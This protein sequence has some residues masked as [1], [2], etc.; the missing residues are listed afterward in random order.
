MAAVRIF[1]FRLGMSTIRAN[2]QLRIATVLLSRRCAPHFG[3]A[4][5]LRNPGSLI[6]S[7]VILHANGARRID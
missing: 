3:G 7:I 1:M 5:C 4:A 6:Q 2:M